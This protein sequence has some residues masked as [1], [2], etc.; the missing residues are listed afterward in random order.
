MLEGVEV[1]GDEVEK[2]KVGVGGGGVKKGGV[3][4]EGKGEVV[5]E[6]GIEIG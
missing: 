2:K 6:S 1:G 3:G 5:N 4:W